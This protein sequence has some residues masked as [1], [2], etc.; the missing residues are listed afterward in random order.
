MTVGKKATVKVWTRLRGPCERGVVG[1]EKIAVSFL[2]KKKKRGRYLKATLAV[3]GGRAY[4]EGKVRGGREKR[5]NIFL[6]KGG[7]GRLPRS[8]RKIGR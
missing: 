7:R 4:K 3:R 2:P 8:Y 6:G 1:R 5:L